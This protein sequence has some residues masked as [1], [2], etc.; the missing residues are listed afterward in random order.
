MSTTKTYEIMLQTSPQDLP[1]KVME[2][3]EFAFTNSP[4]LNVTRQDMILNVFGVFVEKSRLANSKE[5]RQI[6]EAIEALQ[7]DGYPVISSSG[8]PGY[9][10]A[11]DDQDI[12]EYIIELESRRKQ[13]EEKIRC[14]RNPRKKYIYIPPVVAIQPALI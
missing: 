2:V 11:V 10:L 9:R 5:D 4:G 14:L 3:L 13:L 1:K 8:K 6:R 12:E 7:R